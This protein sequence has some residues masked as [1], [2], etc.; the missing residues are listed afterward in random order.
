MNQEAQSPRMLRDFGL[1]MGGMI[2][3]IFGVLIPL[4]RSRG[5]SVIPWTIALLFAAAALIRPTSLA[6]IHRFWMKF[7]AIVGAVNSRIILTIIFA[8]FITPIAVLFKLL[9]R[10]V[11]R[12]APK[13]P[14]A[15]TYRIAVEPRPARSGMEK[16]F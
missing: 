9:R 4:V 5:I 10:D 2:A 7:S 3:G 6:L 8:V 15:T 16:P 13:D 1:L 11:L 14:D 12:L